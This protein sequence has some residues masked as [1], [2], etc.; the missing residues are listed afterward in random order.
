MVAEVPQQDTVGYG[1]SVEQTYTIANGDTEAKEIDFGRMYSFFLI[2]CEDASNI[3]ASTALSANAAH[4]QDQVMQAVHE[5]D[6]PA[7]VWSEGDLVTTGAFIFILTHAWG[8]RY[9]QLVLSNAA[10]GGTVVF[11]IIGVDPIVGN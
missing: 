4:G 8:A 1:R 2:R 6:L 5:R 3:A 10:S 11:S 7:T 9:L